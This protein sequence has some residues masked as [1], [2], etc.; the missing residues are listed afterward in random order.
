MGKY[1]IVDGDILPEVLVKVVEARKLLRKG[2]VSR[3]T[4]AAKAEL[5]WEI[6]RS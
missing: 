3:I 6:A 4:S 1:Y 5:P 2:K